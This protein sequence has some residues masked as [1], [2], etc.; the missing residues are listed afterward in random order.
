[1]TKVGA[2]R[3]LPLTAVSV[4]ATREPAVAAV[5]ADAKPRTRATREISKYVP[6][7]LVRNDQP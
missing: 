7:K 6:R 3:A 2:A 5:A 4:Q 1:V